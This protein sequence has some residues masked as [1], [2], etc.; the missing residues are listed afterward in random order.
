MASQ[1]QRT[2]KVEAIPCSLR[3]ITDWEC[4]P[5]PL[6]ALVPSATVRYVY[7]HFSFHSVR[8]MQS[9]T[10]NPLYKQV[11]FIY[12]DDQYFSPTTVLRKWTPG[13]SWGAGTSCRDAAAG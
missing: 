4:A 10:S 2:A 1:G 8:T 7:V 6:E 5:C 12:T 9:T 11:W 13:R 3:A